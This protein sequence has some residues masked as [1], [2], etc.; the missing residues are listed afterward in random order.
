MIPLLDGA[1]SL[2]SAIVAHLPEPDPVLRR[3][4]ILSHWQ[5]VVA[6]LE[7]LP[8]LTPAQVGRLARARGMVGAL[9]AS[10]PQ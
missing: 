1:L 5:G 4:R 3:A 6:R 8:K 10:N 2:A 7:A 9:G